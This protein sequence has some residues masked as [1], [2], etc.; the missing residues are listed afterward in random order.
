[1]GDNGVA[2]DIE[3]VDDDIHGI[4]SSDETPADGIASPRSAC[5][6]QRGWRGEH[7]DIPPLRR[8][9][10]LPTIH[11]PQRTHAIDRGPDHRRGVLAGG[12]RTGI[13]APHDEGEHE[14]AI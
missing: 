13:R 1:V 4:L 12:S 6:R 7:R 11:P 3:Q 14:Y 2:G 10:Q 8:I 5:E 9:E